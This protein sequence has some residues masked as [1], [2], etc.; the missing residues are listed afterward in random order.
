MKLLPLIDIL[1][2]PYLVQQYKDQPE[3]AI[4]THSDLVCAAFFDPHIARVIE[5]RLEDDTNYTFAKQQ[6]TSP[7]PWSLNLYAI[8]HTNVSDP[9]VNDSINSVGATLSDGQIIYHGSTDI[10][11]TIFTAP[12]T[13]R[14]LSTTLSPAVAINELIHDSKAYNAE[15]YVIYI[16]TVKDPKT[17]VFVYP[18]SGAPVELPI[19]AD[20]DSSTM[21]GMNELEILFASGACVIV[22]TEKKIGYAT[23]YH[24]SKASKEVPVYI[25]SLIHI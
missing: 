7:L 17:N 2:K 1:K 6:M 3:H 22:D 21:F 23:A 9:R 12:L 5:S 11:R 15:R 10:P 25:L 4:T 14:P 18:D 20:P 8:S 16:L 19:D 24:H 13:T